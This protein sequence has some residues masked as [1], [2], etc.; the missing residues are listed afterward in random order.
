ML[1]VLSRRCRVLFRGMCA[2]KDKLDRNAFGEVVGKFVR[3]EDT[4]MDSGMDSKFNSGPGRG[5]L[6]FEITRDES[7]Q[8]LYD[9]VKDHTSSKRTLT[10]MRFG[11]R[12]FSKHFYHLHKYYSIDIMLFKSILHLLEKYNHLGFEIYCRLFTMIDDNLDAIE[13]DCD[14]YDRILS[15]SNRLNFE[16]V[17][18]ETLR[19]KVFDR[20]ERKYTDLIMSPQS[21]MW[22]QNQRVTMRLRY[23]RNFA[24]VSRIYSNESY[25]QMFYDLLEEMSERP[26]MIWIK[27]LSLAFSRFRIRFYENQFQE[28]KSAELEQAGEFFWKCWMLRDINGFIWTSGKR[29]SSGCRMV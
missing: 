28:S 21:L 6:V 20:I 10:K 29:S 18:L 26:R 13:L 16:D 24:N 3:F 4:L 25:A 12:A 8:A 7:L 19:R 17:E 22:G 11:Q 9:L 23:I 5:E 14:D 2:N 1:G 27:D 15:F